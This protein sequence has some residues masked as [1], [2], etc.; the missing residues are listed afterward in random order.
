MMATPEDVIWLP[1]SGIQV[2]SRQA[3]PRAALQNKPNKLVCQE[4]VDRCGAKK[5]YIVQWY[6]Q[7]PSSFVMPT[8]H[9][10]SIR[11]GCTIALRWIGSSKQL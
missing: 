11:N 7:Q 6:M 9:K 5:C 3:G 4:I 1:R 2:H 10:T 8:I